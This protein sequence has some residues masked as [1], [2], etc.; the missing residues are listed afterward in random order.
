[1]PVT[2]GTDIRFRRVSN[3]QNLSQVRVDQIVQDEQGFMWFGTWNGLNRYDG[4][5]F[6]VF[7]HEAGNPASLSGVYIYSLFKDRA[8]TLWVGTDQFLDRFD[9]RTESFR[10]YPID[11]PGTNDLPTIVTHISQDSRGMLWL[12]TRNGLFRL[13][14]KTGKMKN[15]RHDSADPLTL[16]DSDIKSTGEDRAGRFWVGTSQTLDEFDRETGRVKRHVN[17]GESGVGLWFHQDRQG[18]FWV[19]CNSFGRIATLDLA[20]NQLTRYEF[21]WGDGPARPNQAYSMLE[22]RDGVMWFGTADAGLMRFD[23]QNS[24]FIS[25]SHHRDDSDSI[26][27]TRVIALFE[28]NEGN[29]WTGLHQA[30]PNFFRTRPL[31]FEDLTRKSGIKAGQGSRLAGTIF[32]DSEGTIWIGVNRQLMRLNRRTGDISTLKQTANADVLSII[33]GGEN[34]LWLGNARPGLLRY[35]FK[36]GESTGYRHNRADSTTLCSGIVQR[37]LIDR[38]GA[39]WSATWD[40]LCGFD[41]STGQFTTYKPDPA[42]RGLNYYTIAKANDGALWLGGNLGLHRFDPQAKT[43]TVYRHDPDD[44]TSLSD[45]R[46]NAILFDKKGQLWA[47]T[48]NGLDKLDPVRR[49]FRGYDQR[50]GMAGN[51][52]SCILE[53]SHGLLWM[54]TNKGVSSFNPATERFANYGTADGLPGPDLTGW[55]A[56]YKSSSGEMFFAGFSG[57]ASFFPD[58]VLEDAEVPRAV[59]T[60][61][62]LFGS[63]V[64]PGPESPLKVAIN[65]TSAITLSHE[66]NVFSIEFAGLTYLNP[67]TNRY[68]YKLDGLDHTWHEVRSDERVAAYTTLP[69]DSYTFHVQA[70]TSRGQWSPEVTLAIE[71]LPPFRRTSWFQFASAS[72]LSVGLWVAYRARLERISQQFNVRLEERVGERTRI[73]QELHDTLLQNLTGLAL[74]ISGL[75]KT[76]TSPTLARERLQD[77]REQAEACLRE[78][79]QSL[80]DIRSPESD[81]IDL[82][83]ELNESGKQFT[84]DRPTHFEFVTV[85][86]PRPI[87]PDVRQQLLRIGRE[88]ISN[89]AQHA[90]ASRIEVRLTYPE[91]ALALGIADDYGFD[92]VDAERLPGHF[93]LATMRERAAVIRGQITIHSKI[94]G[95]TRV[96]V[97]VPERR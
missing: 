17:T 96:E 88:A 40:G 42:T 74:Q 39:L 71:I 33:D 14:P 30:E 10:H 26:G 34:V 28:D 59:L 21:D 52:V 53:D 29:I 20:T 72:F 86:E 70:A 25:Y 48:Q 4:Y 5:K 19:I 32:E 83:H 31:P 69:P 64:A 7:K 55:G 3:P 73:A 22:D 93:G 9:P 68:R 95:G 50:H 12:S 78:A 91:N 85:G 62:R 63:P 37:L 41:A 11:K 45:N 60:E 43:F 23:R 75:A 18:V 90:Y 58:K 77:L 94:E 27:D 76:I 8:G 16:G 92:L 57:I 66:Q 61:L 87:R 97:I 56:C 65:H 54:S 79:L 36:T 82:A 47:G 15:Y 1:M 35:N 44:V 38:K 84:S 49:F 6:K 46:V 81:S 67:A 89:A 51:A 80:W 13:D 2:E 24:R